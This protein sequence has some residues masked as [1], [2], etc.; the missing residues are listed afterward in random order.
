MAA[1]LKLSV[2][3]LE[4]VTDAEIILTKNRIIAIVQD[5]YAE[6]I[7]KYTDILQNLRT[8]LP[9]EALDV[10][11]KIS[12]GEQYEG[13]P[14]VMFDYPRFFSKQDVF[15]VRSFFW[16]GNF[17]SISLHLEGRFKTRF[18][19]N[20]QRSIKNGH[21]AGYYY[22][23]NSNPWKHDFSENNY[24]NL[25]SVDMDQLANAAFIKLAIKLP[26]KDWDEAVP[27][28]EKCFYQLM[29]QLSTEEL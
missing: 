10:P 4:L 13:L 6:L 21:F 8:S 15:A 20:I 17:F 23:V 24:V 16:W 12:K 3:E 14:Y 25:G 19:E 2:K 27:F 1:N 5:L 18:Q 22:C 7:P 9:H 29:E 11:P 26:L 28:Y